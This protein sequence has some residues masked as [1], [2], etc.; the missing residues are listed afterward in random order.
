VRR[1]YLDPYFSVSSLKLIPQYSPLVLFLCS[2]VIGLAVVW[3]I[4]RSAFKT[5]KGA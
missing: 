4:L 5:G 3:F 2:L 1:A